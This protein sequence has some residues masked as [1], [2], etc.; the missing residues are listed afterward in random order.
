MRL[1]MTVAIAGGLAMIAN[2]E[3]PIRVLVV[4]GSHPFDPRLYATIEGHEDIVWDKKTQLPNP[5]RAFDPGFAEG[6]DV[7]VLYDFEQEITEEQKQSFLDAFRD[8]R[9]LLVWHHALCS[10]A[11]WPAYR[12]LTGGQ[13]LFAPVEGIPASSFTGNV[14]M[15]YEP[16]GSGHPIAQGLEPFEAVEEPYKDVWQAEGCTPLLASPNPESDRVVAWAK[17]DRKSRVVCAVPGHGGE[18]FVMPEFKRFMAQSIRWLAKR[19]PV[20]AAKKDE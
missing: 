9:G 2:A 6:Y 11:N 17:E 18:I 1:W 14:K 10:H 13:F 7:I 5:C 15:H 19:E 4:T 3:A 8:G 16:A 12:E 20:R